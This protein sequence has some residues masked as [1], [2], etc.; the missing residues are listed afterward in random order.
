[1]NLEDLLQSIEQTRT[2]EKELQ[3]RKNAEREALTQLLEQGL[4]DKKISTPSLSISYVSTKRW[5]YS[6]AVKQLQEMEQATGKAK[7]SIS[8]S[9]RIVP[10]KTSQKS[11]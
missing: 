9:W 11:S 5:S 3:Q 7:C 10:Q 6:P 2:M 1:M 4:I 8:S